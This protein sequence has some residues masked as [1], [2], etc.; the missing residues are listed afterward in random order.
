MLK[1]KVNIKGLRKKLL[2]LEYVTRFC[3]VNLESEVKQ[4]PNIFFAVSKGSDSLSN[5]LAFDKPLASSLDQS[6]HNHN[7]RIVSSKFEPLAVTVSNDVYSNLSRPQAKL[8]AEA[9]EAITTLI[10]RQS[11]QDPDH[12]N[13]YSIILLR[14]EPFKGKL[15]LKGTQSSFHELKKKCIKKSILKKI[16]LKSQSNLNLDKETQAQW[17]KCKYV[18]W[19]SPD[20]TNL[21]EQLIQLNLLKAYI[22]SEPRETFIGC[23]LETRN[24]GTHADSVAISKGY[25]FYYP[26]QLF[27]LCDAIDSFSQPT[28][29]EILGQLLHTIDS[30]TNSISTILALNT[31][32][33]KLSS[34]SGQS[35]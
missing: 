8:E 3:R 31:A 19:V 34:T 11:R 6:K 18:Y 35:D 20:A 30:S 16:F 23:L 2:N 4:A 15:D 12:F 33:L 9:N 28:G 13:N 10:D 1:K 14:T 22:R 5:E 26:S 7:L 29:L 25:Q 21:K 32:R 17:L 27:A 24:C